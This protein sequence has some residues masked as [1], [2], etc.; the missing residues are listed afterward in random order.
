MELPKYGNNL[1]WVDIVD[2]D[3][4]DLSHHIVLTIGQLI[5]PE[6]E[7]DFYIVSKSS[8]FEKTVIFLRNQGIP[9]ELISPAQDEIKD[10]KP[11]GTGRRGR[12]KKVQATE[13]APVKTGKRGRP[14]KVQ[15]AV[16]P[17]TENIEVPK[18]KRGRPAAAKAPV[19]EAIPAEPKKRGRKKKEVAVVAAQPAAAEQPVVVEKPKRGRKPGV[20]NEKTKKVKAVKEAKPVKAAKAIKAPKAPKEAKP[21]KAA[22]AVKAPKEAKPAKAA[23]AEKAP[24]APKAEKAPKAAKVVKPAKA[25]K[26]P[27][28]AKP[29]KAAK[30]P[31]ATK[32]AKPRKQR[33]DKE[34]T[35]Q[36]VAE[37]VALYPTDDTNLSTVMSNLFGMKKVARPKF[38][39]KLVDAVKLITL[40]DDNEAEKIIARLQELNILD[41]SGVGGRISYKD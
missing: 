27:K 15:E 8:K 25:A 6:E 34:I 14:K 4:S 3:A 23:K 11:K 38:L 41:T 24:K 31:K 28:A 13:N 12:P 7:I 17:V 36:Q 29:V 1:I 20:K 39:A 30:T 37:K 10:E 26:V 18:K 33:I 35:V 16:V 32:E 19:T 21:V 40:D 2:M 22:K 5:N 9:A